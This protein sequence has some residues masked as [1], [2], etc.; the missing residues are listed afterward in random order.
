MV[1]SSEQRAVFN[2][3]LG[4]LQCKSVKKHLRIVLVATFRSRFCFW[5]VT[6]CWLCT[7]LRAEESQVSHTWNDVVQ[8]W[9][10]RANRLPAFSVEYSEEV[11]THSDVPEN[12]GSKGRKSKYSNPIAPGDLTV[13]SKTTFLADRMKWKLTTVGDTWS[14]ELEQIIPITSARA[15]DGQIRTGYEILG[16]EASHKS[17]PGWV[18]S[19]Q[20]GCLFT[21]QPQLIPWMILLRPFEVGCSVIS[22]DQ[23]APEG[24]LQEYYLNDTDGALLRQE[25]KSNQGNGGIELLLDAR[26]EF[27]LRRYRSGN[28][29]VEIEFKEYPGYGWLPDQYHSISFDQQSGDVSYRLNVK[30]NS[31]QFGV[32]V[33]D[34]DFRLDFP[35]GTVVRDTTTGDG[36]PKTYYVKSDGTEREITPREWAAGIQYSRLETSPSDGSVSALEQNSNFGH[37][38]ILFNVIAIVVVLALIGARWRSK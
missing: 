4:W 2:P 1:V 16:G 11:F 34:S 32:P 29:E 36:T 6:F 12:A 25:L 21:R 24:P 15:F 7:L 37:L 31:I 26:R 8:S 28:V 20:S 35:P 30:V 9:T 19:R 38:I 33:Q 3:W 5:L 14:S 18:E 27:A 23:W 17:R 22:P 13:T 10:D